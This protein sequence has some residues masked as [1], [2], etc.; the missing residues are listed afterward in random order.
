MRQAAVAAVDGEPIDRIR[1]V[2]KL[3]CQ[4]PSL[5][6]IAFEVVTTIC[7]LKYFLK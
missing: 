5:A 6:T 3:T 7:V 4:C 1:K 2:D